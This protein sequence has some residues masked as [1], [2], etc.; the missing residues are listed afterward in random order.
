MVDYQG[1]ELILED[2]PTHRLPNQVSVAHRKVDER[3]TLVAPAM[4]RTLIPADE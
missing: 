2:G 4:G 3:T 1:V